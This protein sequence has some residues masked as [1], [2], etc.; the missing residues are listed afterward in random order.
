MS[1]PDF[2]S[3]VQAGI[4]YLDQHVQTPKDWRQRLLR[5][6]PELDMMSDE[7]TVL[8]IIFQVEFF[9][10][11]KLLELPHTDAVE[12]MGFHISYL[13]AKGD[14]QSGETVLETYKR[15][16]SVLQQTW[17]SEVTPKE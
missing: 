6:A 9:A 13:T 16:Y 12:L 8:A 2:T 3:K 15:L 14:R 1:S 10:A 7:Q 11:L 4:K 17:L 5:S